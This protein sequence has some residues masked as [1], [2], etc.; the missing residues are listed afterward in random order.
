MNVSMSLL[1]RYI[2]VA[3]EGFVSTGFCFEA[4]CDD[5]FSCNT[6]AVARVA[7]ICRVIH[8][9]RVPLWYDVDIVR[10]EETA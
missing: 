4:S 6:E 2:E 8:R 7:E 9:K 3:L 10:T 1:F 5:N